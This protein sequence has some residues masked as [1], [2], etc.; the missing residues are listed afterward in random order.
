M[1]LWRSGLGDVWMDVWLKWSEVWINQLM[2]K[3][4]KKEKQPWLLIE[5]LHLSTI[6]SIIT[7]ILLNSLGTKSKWF[8]W[9]WVLYG[10]WYTLN[11]WKL[12]WIF[13]SKKTHQRIDFEMFWKS[14]RPSH[15]MRRGS[16]G[17]YCKL[18]MCWH[19]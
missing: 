5:F 18:I 2:A 13:Y 4:T 1:I 19:N 14:R 15:L 3:V 7:I 10:W 9:Y 16:K 17:L 6:V 8:N 11:T 12:I